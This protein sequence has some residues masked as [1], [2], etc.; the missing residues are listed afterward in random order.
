MSRA[1]GRHVKAVDAANRNTQLQRRAEAKDPL[2]TV[3]KALTPDKSTAD[4]VRE[5]QLTEILKN[6]TS[7]FA[8]KQDRKAAKRQMGLT[9]SPR[10]R[11]KPKK[12]SS[13]VSWEAVQL[14]RAMQRIKTEKLI[15]DCKAM[16]KVAGVYPT[17][18]KLAIATR[19]DLLALNGVGPKTLE[20]IHMYLVRRQV[21]LKWKPSGN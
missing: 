18:A 10:T 5:V 4:K 21:P 6:K 2:K 19:E 12:H 20:Q 9:S 14:V 7:N 16:A 3:T 13:T 11:L 1:K 15:P 8:D 17:V